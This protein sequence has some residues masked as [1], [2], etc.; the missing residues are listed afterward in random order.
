MCVL[1]AYAPNARGRSRHGR[2]V[3]LRTQRTGT[4][5]AWASCGL[6]HPTHGD[7]SGLGGLRAYSP[8]ARGRSRHGRP[9]G[10]RM[11]GHVGR[12]GCSAGARTQHAGMLPGMGGLWI[13]PNIRVRVVVD[14]FPYIIDSLEHFNTKEGKELSIAGSRAFPLRPR[15]WKPLKPGRSYSM[16]GCLHPRRDGARA[17]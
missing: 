1:E 10:L 15:R 3:G 6:T 5:P 4:L 16:V 8:N 11:H 7:A 9:V 14:L 2:P 12:L 17:F 13:T